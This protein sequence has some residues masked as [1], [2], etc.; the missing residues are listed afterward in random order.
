LAAFAVCLL[1]LAAAGVARA[2]DPYGPT[3]PPPPMEPKPDGWFEVW[4]G[5]KRDLLKATG[6]TVG[7]CLNGTS[8]TNL[9]GPQEGRAR[10]VFWWNLHVDQ[11]LWPGAK[12]IVNTRGGSGNGMGPLVGDKLN[13]NWMAGEPRCIYVSHLLLEQKLWDDKL[14]FWLGKLDIDDYFDT[15]AAGSWNFLSYSLARNPTVPCP[16]HAVGAVA[17]YEPTEWLYVQAGAVDAKGSVTETG[18]NTAFHDED[19]FFSMYEFGLRLRPGGRRGYYRF[20]VWYDPQPVARINGTGSKRDD[21]GFALS[22]DQQLTDGITAFFRYGF[23]H[24][25]VRET[26]SFWSLGFTWTGPIPQRSEDVLA[27]GVGQAIMSRD[28]RRAGNVSASAETLF[29]LYYDIKIS[30]WCRLT[31]DLQVI[32]NPGANTGNDVAVLLGLKLCLNL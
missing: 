18:L 26:T 29:E 4:K 6:T 8:Q 5:W 11:Q 17:R 23:A 31:P 1:A 12:L 27:F 28:S 21:V 24:E 9:N 25:E 16:W 30:E 15:N 7:L 10:S 2:E 19:Y 32:L 22:F 3:A 14:T 20:L 13:T